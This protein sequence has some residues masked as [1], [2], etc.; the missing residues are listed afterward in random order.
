MSTSQ[1]CPI[2]V[3][4]RLRPFVAREQGQEA[5]IKIDGNIVSLNEGENEKNDK[6]YAFDAAFDSMDPASPS[7]ASQER[8]YTEFGRT[9]L[10]HALQG[11]NSTIFAYGQTG[12]GKTTTIMGSFNPVS[13]Q[14]ILIR[15]VNE[16][17][18]EVRKLRADG[19]KVEC[20]ARML[21]VY[22]EKIQDLLT[23]AH[24]K[25]K[26][27]Y[28]M[29]L[30]VHLHPVFGVYV[31]GLTDTAVETFTECA[32]LITYG[33]AMKSVAATAMNAKSSR[34]HTLFIIRFE[35]NDGQD[36]DTTV[37]EIYF[38]DL[39][40]RE[41]ERTT[42]VK[43]DRLI[44]L[45]FINKSL[46]HLST[47]IHSLSD[48]PS[49]SPSSPDK[50]PKDGA[51]PSD[52][53]SLKRSSSSASVASGASKK[54]ANISSQF[55][56]SKLTM[57]LS[58]ALS[59]NSKTA[60]IGT[61]SP[62]ASNLDEN[63][64]TLNFAATVKNI[65][66]KVSASSVNKK[67]LVQ[68]LQEE[69]Q[70]LKEQLRRSL[71][72]NAADEGEGADA[73]AD[74]LAATQSLY[75]QFQKSW[76][77]SQKEAEADKQKRE[78]VMSSM[79]VS[80]WKAISRGKSTNA[81]ERDYPYIQNWSDDPHLKGTLTFHAP[82]DTEKLVGSADD[83]NFVLQGLGICKHHCYLNN[84]NARLHIRLAPAENGVQPRVEVNGTSLG[85]ESVALQHHDCVLFGRSRAFHVITESDG[86]APPPGYFDQN[87]AK[88]ETLSN[89]ELMKALLGSRADDEIQFN[90]AKNYCAQLQGM[91]G[92]STVAFKAFLR[93]AKKVKRMVDEANEITAAVRPGDRLAFELAMVAPPLSFGYSQLNLPIVAVRLVQHMS[94]GK[95]K[96]VGRKP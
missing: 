21:E 6:R 16:L 89:T 1:P 56:N 58:K 45:S 49:G 69:V 28:K 96:V 92:E 75:S 15:L 63:M 7:Y 29:K 68:S 23:P 93:S 73:L 54:S 47:C 52:K 91:D 42:Q 44:E 37:S 86:S 14:G 67:D 70:Q 40:G 34:A 59:G 90:N 82:L 3:A 25:E 4:V 36:L 72:P 71:S 78:R 57:L 32:D 88:E 20:R 13:E 46:F 80:L 5:I 41:N 74:K 26:N 33:N 77:E 38:V 31:P 62:A 85:A 48:G 55:R 2:S 94:V 83:C 51:S 95:K 10:D 9:L 79:G 84:D 17:F 35:K 11:F 39:A 87:K 64:S 24:Q 30:D 27:K 22:N 53:P 81:L 8:V 43:G 61:L 18:E 19:Y 50:I 60:M 12:T 66:L 76:E 65:K